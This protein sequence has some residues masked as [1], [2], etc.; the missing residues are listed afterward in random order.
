MAFST[1]IKGH[2]YL[3]G[4]VQVFFVRIPVKWREAVLVPGSNLNSDATSLLP[5]QFSNTR[6]VGE[7]GRAWRKNPRLC[8]SVGSA[9]CVESHC[10]VACILHASRWKWF[11]LLWQVSIG[12]WGLPLDKCCES[13]K[14]TSVLPVTLL[15]LQICLQANI[16]PIWVKPLIHAGSIRPL[17]VAEFFAPRSSEN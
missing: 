3:Q 7:F 16:E 2:L 8:G 9:G 13:T 17:G 5:C 10:Q 6:S 12:K 4:N 11:P 15:E 1:K 14:K